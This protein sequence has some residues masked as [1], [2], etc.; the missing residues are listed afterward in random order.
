M[1][2]KIWYSK[3][4]MKR[5]YLLFLFFLFVCILLP[6]VEAKEIFNGFV[7][8][9]EQ[10]V[11]DSQP[12]TFNLAG[13]RVKFTL[14]DSDF[15]I[16]PSGQCKGNSIY[17]FCVL[18]YYDDSCLAHNPD[19]STTPKCVLGTS[20]IGASAPAARISID[21]KEVK[22]TVTSSLSNATLFL[23]EQYT[24]KLTLKND[25]DLP[26][27]NIGIEDTFPTELRLISSNF[28][29]ISRNTFRYE[30]SYL[31][32]GD[33]IYLEYVVVPQK[34]VEATQAALISYTAGGKS[35][36]ISQ[37]PIVVKLSAPLLT[38]F[39]FLNNQ[40]Q[41]VTPDS[42]VTYTL[43]I[44]LTNLRPS[45]VAATDFFIQYPSKWEVVSRDVRFKAGNF[46]GQVDQS[47]LL[48]DKIKIL[49]NGE[50]TIPISYYVDGF[51]YTTEVKINTLKKAAVSKE[52]AYSYSMDLLIPR[53]GEFLEGSVTTIGAVFK[54]T[55]DLP[56]TNVVVVID[57][58]D[59]LIESYPIS[60]ILPGNSI[61]FNS[62]PLVLPDVVDTYQLPVRLF[63]YAGNISK[64]ISKSI[65]VFPLQ[66]AVSISTAHQRV[67]DTEFTI[68][69]TLKNNLRQP[70]REIETI[71]YIPQNVYSTQSEYYRYYPL[72]DSSS[73]IILNSFK[74]NVPFG[75]TATLLVGATVGDL[76]TDFFA[77][78]LE[79]YSITNTQPAL[80]SLDVSVLVPKS[81]AV[82]TWVD[83]PITYYN[84]SST[85]FVKIRSNFVSQ[86]SLHEFVV[87]PYL[88]ELAPYEKITRNLRIFVYDNSTST[89]GRLFVY[90]DDA[91]LD[92][93][94]SIHNLSTLILGELPV[95]IDGTYEFRG[96]SIVLSLEQVKG[97]VA[98]VEVLI[99]N[100]TYAYSLVYGKQ[101]EDSILLTELEALRILANG[102]SANM[103]VSGVAVPLKL[104]FLRPDLEI[105][106]PNAVFRANQ[107]ESALTS[108]NVT[109][110]QDE[111][112]SS[113]NR[114]VVVTNSYQLKVFDGLSKGNIY[115]LYLGVLLFVVIVYFYWRLKE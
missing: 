68:V 111:L 47:I 19:V 54:N 69:Q 82:G 80:G 36:E 90:Y 97:S 66:K 88:V 25:G 77:Y 101:V 103:F 33:T 86:S 64:N 37:K 89:L 27:S 16:V 30:R 72:I 34:F 92:M 100:K 15:Y 73:S 81:I 18:A 40:N 74:V 8:G 63:G 110:T 79:N 58:G 84:P 65:S 1:F 11:V 12:I 61:S 109:Q 70:I 102:L 107:T 6:H 10:K 91:N 50:Y 43:Q 71:T 49:E 31:A 46:S 48:E 13:G 96:S 53:Q 52:P 29:S 115:Y 104:D 83:I 14:D 39:T 78:H 98:D 9:F 38:T 7:Y 108:P 112:E 56:L 28:G 105:V 5:A 75:E 85:R 2:I 57:A 45:R 44:N 21:K 22:L 20:S 95:D 17:T 99:G 106:A 55:G 35:F 59:Y 4:P 3:Y 67:S 26:I 76:S 113:L 23:N 62:K 93:Y 24:V 94:S 87:D 32:P 114:D 60:Q 41:K 42:N 51:F